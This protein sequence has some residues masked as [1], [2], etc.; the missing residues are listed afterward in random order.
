MRKRH[1]GLI[2]ASLCLIV[3]GLALGI[4]AIALSGGNF[5][6]LDDSKEEFPKEY[7]IKEN[8]SSIYIQG[9]AGN[10][11]IKPSADGV[12]RVECFDK[13][14]VSHT[15]SVEGETLSVKVKDERRWYDRISL[16]SFW[17]SNGITLF[18]PKGEYNSIEVSSS[19]ADITLQSGFSFAN[20]S[21]ASSTGDMI[22]F[23]AF[24][25]DFTALTDTGDINLSGVSAAAVTV[26]ANT[27]DIT[28]DEVKSA[29]C[30]NIT[31][32]T[33]EIYSAESSAV[34]ARFK[35]DTG[36]MDIKFCEFNYAEI[37]SN[38][39]DILLAQSTATKSIDIKTST[40]DI[41]FRSFD[42][43]E[44]TVK[45]STGDVEGNIRTDK[46]FTVNTSTGKVRVPSDKGDAPCSITTSTGD[47]N[48]I[49][50]ETDDGRW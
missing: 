36:D 34:T 11:I 24:S 4:L 43:G 41:E 33:G 27:G 8:Y 22:I 37:E 23:G 26:T 18:L 30:L 40:G 19:T 44:I 3:I 45:T 14:K 10:I 47:I 12:T 39:A 38:T 28:L 17:D 32:D 1:S 25:G 31:T 5:R 49:I 21:F 15:V 42:A 13:E 6:F 35:S 50:S 16:F 48:I 29:G 20:G 7:E 2:A 9:Y 46:K